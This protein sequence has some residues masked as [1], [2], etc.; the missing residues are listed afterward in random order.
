VVLAD[1]GVKT[2]EV[3][4]LSATDA[5][6][7]GR[8]QRAARTKLLNLIDA[9]TDLPKTLG[10]DAGEATQPYRP[11]AVAGVAQ[12]W[13]KVGSHEQP[14]RAW[15]GPTLPGKPF[16]MASEMSCVL[17]TGD[18]VKA[19]LDAARDAHGSTPWLSGGQRWL[20]HVRPLLPDESGCA[21]LGKLAG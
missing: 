12:R 18:A 11:T 1:S 15:P 14:E 19:V 6:G 3:Y 21:D 4:A 5:I 7:V 8:P 10:A 17:V 20:L 16:D 13:V 9:L 2:T